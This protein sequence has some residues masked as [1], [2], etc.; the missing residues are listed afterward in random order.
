[1]LVTSEKYAG[2][3]QSAVFSRTKG[4]PLTPLAYRGIGAR[5]TL[6]PED[7]L[8]ATVWSS[9]SAGSR[10]LKEVDSSTTAHMVGIPLRL[11]SEMIGVLLARVPGEVPGTALE[12][13]QRELDEVTLRLATALA[14][15]DVRNLVTADE[16]QRLA[17][18]IHDGVAQEVASLGYVVDELAAE[19]NDP[20]VTAGLQQLRGEL[21]RIVTELR[22]SIFDLRS[23]VGDG[24]GLGSALS[25]Y[26]RKVGARSAMTVHLSL[27]EAPTRLSPGVETELFR[28]AQE[29]ITNARKHSQAENLW[30]DCWVRAAVGSYDGPRR[31]PRCWGR[32]LRLL[33]LAHHAGA[34]GAYR[35]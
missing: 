10:F 22:L 20:D 5:E 6:F 15:D 21:S 34:S 32:P 33:R 11:G 28:I 30:V 16:R 2:R 26:V 35:R 8:I 9:A 19:S 24:P 4:G 14:F 17:R 13:L 7:E 27:D 31:R 3:G 23:E 12:M 18:E 25:D 1:M 29:A